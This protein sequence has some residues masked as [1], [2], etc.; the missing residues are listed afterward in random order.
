[1]KPLWNSERQICKRCPA[2]QLSNPPAD[3][4]CIGTQTDRDI[5]PCMHENTTTLISG[6]AEGRLGERTGFVSEY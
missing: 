2:L 6:Q 4:A 5:C 3:A 1:M